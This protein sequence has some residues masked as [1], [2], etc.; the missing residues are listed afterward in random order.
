LFPDLLWAAVRHDVDRPYFGIDL[1]QP[2]AQ[3]GVGGDEVLSDGQRVLEGLQSV[4][5]QTMHEVGLIAYRR[6]LESYVVGI[7]AGRL[8]QQPVAAV[9]RIAD[10]LPS[11]GQVLV[12]RL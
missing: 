5:A 1:V 6:Q 8:P 9:D 3:I 2:R 4:G 11:G 12:E 10:G 7:I